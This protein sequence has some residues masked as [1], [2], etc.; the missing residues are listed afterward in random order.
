MSYSSFAF[1]S[2]AWSNAARPGLFNTVALWVH[3]A[4]Q[5]ARDRQALGLIDDWNLQDLGPNRS[6]IDFELAKP[7]WRA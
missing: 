5:R 7:F 4:R 2:D 3:R 6:Q 1:V